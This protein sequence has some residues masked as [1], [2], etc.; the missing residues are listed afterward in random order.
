MLFHSRRM[1]QKS[2]VTSIFS[3]TLIICLLSLISV[4]VKSSAEQNVSRKTFEL[5]EKYLVKGN[6]QR[7]NELYKKL[8]YYPLQ[9]YLQQQNIVKNMRLSSAKEIDLFLSEHRGSPLDWPLRKKWL[10]YLDKKKQAALFLKFFK[11]TSNTSLTC[12]FHLYQLQVGVAK[13]IVLPKVTKLWQVGK[14][15]PKSCDPLFK[16]WQN[17]GYRTT[18]VIWQRIAIAADGGK[19]TLLP[20][21]IKQLPDK[22][23]R[24]GELWRSVRIN[25]SYVANL[26]RF[27]AKDSKETEIVTYALKRYIWRDP[28]NAIKVFEKAKKQFP[29]TESQLSAIT[30][31]FAIS[32]SSKGHD[33]AKAWLAKLSDHQYSSNL[34]QW[35][36][37][38]LVRSEDWPMIK[39]G[40]L[41]FPKSQQGKNQWRY[42]YGKSLIKT[43][44]QSEGNLLLQK[45]ALE[46]HYYGF[47]AAGFL[48]QQVNLQHVPIS[49]SETEKMN[50]LKHSAG[51][52]AFEFFHL[53]RYLQA[54]SEWNF[55]LSQLNKKEK[56]VAA[57][58]AFDKGWF[59]RGIFTLANVGYL[60]DVDLRFPMAFEKNITE[61]AKENT[62]N[63]AWAFAI[64]RRESSFM[65]DAQSPV[66][67]SGLMQ[68]MPAT[69]KQLARK[70]MSRKK[71][72]NPEQNIKLGT[73]YLNQ[74][75]KKYSGNQILATA[76][77]NA[78]PYRVKA[79]LKA[80]PKMPADI[81][82]E[83]IPFKE[84]REYV[85]SVMA[86]Q[87][88]YLLKTNQPLKLFEQLSKMTISKL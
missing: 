1:T 7:F 27:K 25:P 84:T 23:K 50:V 70:K 87:Q 46:R 3:T 57:K 88:I 58:I 11:P 77:Y 37:T 81:W 14:S 34:M 16:I 71:L 79:W 13:S 61:H 41:T 73:K 85:K 76:A 48:K 75:Q 18:E 4:S 64:A 12:K 5:A 26:S 2:L 66:G 49:V 17:Q 10:N 44:N 32:L 29:F 9:P 19:S 24:K 21:L 47:L 74:L 54:R 80:R 20:Y 36:I 15:Q 65:S 69:A 40:L 38:E 35:R 43:G 30:E 63:P 28:D 78:G 82:I 53:G 51:K 86:Y 45:L 33:K 72:Y 55:W 59:D 56:L 31:K 83:T 22:L 39:K 60:N 42:W 68:L 62:I 67:A 52:R 6:K 8:H